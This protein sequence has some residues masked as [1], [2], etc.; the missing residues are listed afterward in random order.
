MPKLISLNEPN[1]MTPGMIIFGIRINLMS[2]GRHDVDSAEEP[3]VPTCV[4]TGILQGVGH[5]PSSFFFLAFGV[6]PVL[7]Y[8]VVGGIFNYMFFRT[9]SINCI[10]SEESG[11]GEACE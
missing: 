8:I 7:N 5:V 11:D 9:W 10:S 2:E 3:L 1:F 6:V 4:E